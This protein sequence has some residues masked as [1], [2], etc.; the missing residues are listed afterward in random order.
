MEIR[1]M[2]KTTLYNFIKSLKN[3]VNNDLTCTE[4]GL[5]FSLIKDID[6][7]IDLK[8]FINYCSNCR[9]SIYFIFSDNN[10]FIFTDLSR[11]TS[12]S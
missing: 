6:H 1:K 4:C 5:K 7:E 10:C 2:G 3:E 9:Y 12:C 11:R 8:C